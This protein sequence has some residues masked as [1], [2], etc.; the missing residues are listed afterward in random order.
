MMC[1]IYVTTSSTQEAK[2]IASTLLKERLIGC[3]NIASNIQSM[4]WW[5]E[6]IE[7]SQETLLFLKTSQSLTSQVMARVRELH[8]YDC[9][10]ITALPITQADKDF[11]KWLETSLKLA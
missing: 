8:S 5:E 1:L 3:A 2:T 7:E 6:K 11:T 4:Y 9:P 10:C